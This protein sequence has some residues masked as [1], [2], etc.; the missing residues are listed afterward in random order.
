MR[1][2]TCAAEMLVTLEGMTKPAMQWADERGLKWQT[3][4]MRRFR[5]WTWSEAL[6]PEL[7][8]RSR[9]MECWSCGAQPP[10]MPC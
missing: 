8:P 5:G 6:H 9:W 4:K 2:M 3:V 1:S 7:R 10:A